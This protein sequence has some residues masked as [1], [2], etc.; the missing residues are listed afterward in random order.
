MDYL[1]GL[2]SYLVP[3]LG[4]IYQKRYSKGL[5][6][7]VSLYLLFFYGM[8]MGQWSNVYLPHTNVKDNYLFTFR[9]LGDVENRVHFAGQFCIGISAWP[10]LI[11]YY[12]YDPLQPNKPLPI[13]QTY[14]QAPSEEKLNDFQRKG[15]K[16]WDLGWVYTVIAGVLNILV[17]YDAIAGPAHREV[18]EE[19]AREKKEA[20]V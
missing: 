3:G 7:L 6:F 17:I 9:P 10:A 13:I 14:Q 19:P 5:L 1:A 4:Q 20:V 8:W 18:K 12:A 11:Q 2:L 16:R 15:D